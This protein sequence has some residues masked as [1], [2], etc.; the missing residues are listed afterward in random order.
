MAQW[1]QHYTAVNFCRDLLR[2]RFLPFRT[3]K[4]SRIGIHSYLE[5]HVNLSGDL[6][7][8][9]VIFPFYLS[10]PLLQ[11]TVAQKN[12]VKLLQKNILCHAFSSSS[13]PPRICCAWESGKNAVSF[14]RA[15]P[16]SAFARQPFL[17]RWQRPMWMQM[18]L[19]TST[20]MR[21]DMPGQKTIQNSRNHVWSL[22]AELIRWGIWE[23]KYSWQK[24]LRLRRI[25]IMQTFGESYSKHL[26]W[27]LL[28]WHLTFLVTGKG[29]EGDT[30]QTP[31]Y[32]KST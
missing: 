2:D 24:V 11:K 31:W 29:R 19:W 13:S 27:I 28:A 14:P 9:L 15:L 16:L 26:D 4:I 22:F 3:Q 1:F 6:H 21:W 12:L 8:M 10:P 7:V 25:L 18:T 32:L 23:M 30:R 5:C 17:L 20:C